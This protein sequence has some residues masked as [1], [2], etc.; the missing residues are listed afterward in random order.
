M[1]QQSLNLEADGGKPLCR[2]G[3]LRARSTSSVQI[4]R[5]VETWNWSGPSLLSYSCIG[6]HPPPSVRSILY[7]VCQLK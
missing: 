5:P 2:S 4:D 1:V 3:D 6:C 7:S